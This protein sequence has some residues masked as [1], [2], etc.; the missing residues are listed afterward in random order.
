MMPTGS[1]AA[2]SGIPGISR[3]DMIRY[4]A[5]VVGRLHM[6][7]LGGIQR[8]EGWTKEKV[9][10]L[11]VAETVFEIM[12]QQLE[13][14]GIYTD[15]T[16]GGVMEALGYVRGSQ[17]AK[18]VAHEIGCDCHGEFISPLMASQRILNLV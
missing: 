3:D 13:I 12:A 14:M 5:D 6:K 18:N 16:V 4:L 11:P 2:E 17:E 15:G 7:N 8:I 10:D 1:L 9:A